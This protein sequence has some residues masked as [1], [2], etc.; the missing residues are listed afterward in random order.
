MLKLCV[1]H[2]FSLVLGLAVVASCAPAR[3]P[4]ASRQPARRP[5]VAVAIPPAAV[6]ADARLVPASCQGETAE[7]VAQMRATVE[8]SFLEWQAQGSRACATAEEERTRLR[9][10]EDAR[11]H[12]RPG[13]GQESEERA[14]A[15]PHLATN[16]TGTNNRAGVDELDMVKTDDRFVYLATGSALRIVEAL[17]PRVVSLTKLP[18]YARDL[19]VHGD[20]AV[21]YVSSGERPR[22][23]TSECVGYGASN[24]TTWSFETDEVDMR[25]PASPGPPTTVLVFDISNRASPHL[26]RQIDLSGSLVT[27]RRIG[28]AVHTVVTDPPELRQVRPSMPDAVQW[29]CGANEPA[30]VAR[31]RAEVEQLELRTERAMRASIPTIREKG[32][33][34]SLCDDMLRAPLDGRSEY[35]TV[36]SF[37]L[38]AND[39]PPTTVTLEGPPAG[40]YVSPT[41]LYVSTTHVEP[42]DVTSQIHKFRLGEN[43][44]ETRYVATGLL[45]GQ[46]LGSFAMDEWG[47]HLRVATTNGAAVP[48][49][50]S[51]VSVLAERDGAL[52]RVGAVEGIASGMYLRSVHYDGDRVYLVSFRRTTDPQFVVDLHDPARPALLGELEISGVPTYLHRIDPKH[53]LSI[54]FGGG[55]LADNKATGG[56]LLQIVD[57]TSPTHAKLVDKVRIGSLGTC[58]QASRDALAVNYLA[59]RGRLAIPTTICNSGSG[60]NDPVASSGLLLFDVDAQRGFTRVGAVEH[61]TN[62]AYCGQWWAW[63]TSPV[64]RS[65]FADD[66]VYS[67]A[68]DRVKVQRMSQLGRDVADLSLLP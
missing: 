62:G 56:M 24:C 22:S 52:M 36:V 6:L 65:V 41:A 18:G 3:A 32:T 58:S 30:T 42:D 64:K 49:Q 43:P 5:P 38:R 31:V 68:T 28:D 15:R 7:R 13:W 46:V 4:S 27:G 67:I 20:R 48:D 21:V 19:L 17:K 50:Q 63:A 34:R 53:L 11:D 39:A 59:A 12:Y 44:R 47:G 45:P 33:T 26:L 60:H 2:A 57:V 40:H 9:W 35:T 37:D 51:A 54:S 23:T 1:T 61:G 25:S 55:D 16:V 66:L 8:K 29:A 10:R 14:A